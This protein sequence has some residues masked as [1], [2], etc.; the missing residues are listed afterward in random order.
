MEMH[1]FVSPANFSTYRVSTR[2]ADIAWIVT[3]PN[4]RFQSAYACLPA[5]MARVVSADLPLAVFMKI[6]KI[7][8][9]QYITPLT[10]ES[11]IF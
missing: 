7:Q 6:F 1:V 10:S 11:I 3:Y 2:F 5:Q 4:A 9:H 8:F